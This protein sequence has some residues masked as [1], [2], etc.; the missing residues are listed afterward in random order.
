MVR[1]YIVPAFAGAV[2]LGLS[3]AALA[4][5]GELDNCARR[6]LRY[7]RTSRRIALSTR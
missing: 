2:L 6:V 3:T 1:T 7:T 4:V 5:T